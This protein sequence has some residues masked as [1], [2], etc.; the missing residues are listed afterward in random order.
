MHNWRVQLSGEWISESLTAIRWF[1]WKQ[2]TFDVTQRVNIF[3]TVKMGCRF[4]IF[5][6]NQNQL[7]FWNLPENYFAW[8]LHLYLSGDKFDVNILML[9][10]KKTWL[11][12]GMSQVQKCSMVKILR[13]PSHFYK[14][15]FLWKIQHLDLHLQRL[16]GKMWQQ[17]IKKLYFSKLYQRNCILAEHFGS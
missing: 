15:Q 3:G 14:E 12:E 1:L 6:N 16:G 9:K 8:K 17:V 4:R 2:G 13:Y 7:G 10:F 5:L 11:F